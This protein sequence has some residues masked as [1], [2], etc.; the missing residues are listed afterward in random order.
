MFSTSRAC[1]LTVLILLTLTM[2]MTGCGSFRVVREARGGGTVALSGAHDS[3]REKAERYMREQCPGGF[4]V[5]EEGDTATI[6]G[7]Q[8]EW[9]LSYVCAGTS[10]PRTALVAF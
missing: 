1:L 6:V 7:D 5:V 4:E 3:A 8:R 2:T 9:R 10:A